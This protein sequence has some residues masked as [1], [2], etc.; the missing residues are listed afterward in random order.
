MSEGLTTLSNAVRPRVVGRYLGQLGIVLALLN[1]VTLAVS[2]YFGELAISLQYLL[3]ITVLL[4]IAVPLSRIEA[5][6]QIQSNEALV[7]VALA[8]LL[9]P[10]TVVLP[11]ISAGIAPL[12]ALFEALSGV[13]TTGLSTLPSV[14]ALPRTLLFARAWMQWYG[15]L[16][17]VVFTLAILLGY[18]GSA[19]RFIEPGGVESLV[20]TT[21]H[22]ARRMLTLYALLTGLGALLLWPLIGDGLAALLYSLTALST[23]GFSPTDQS[24]ASLH[25]PAA[26][27]VITL[28][29]LGGVPLVLHYRLLHGRWREVIGDS[30]LLL[31]LLLLLCCA[32]TLA[33]VL[34]LDGGMGW[35]EA[36]YHGLL[37]GA[38]GQSTAGFSTM[39]IAQI[40]DSGKF[41]LIVSMFIGGGLGSTAGGIKV[42]RLLI[43][44]RLLQLLLRRTSLPPHAVTV[45]TLQGRE[46]GGDELQR[47][48]VVIFLFVATI[49]LSWFTFLLY[50]Y[51]PLDAL[52]EVVS[53]TGT[54]GL[55]VGI[56]SP[57]L[58]PA[59]K[60]LL[61]FD[62][63]AGRLEIVALL[64]L[65]YPP[66]WFGKRAEG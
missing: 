65:L 47:A 35:G 43:L 2:I 20:T 58:E 12:D 21:R 66:N 1:G 17:I 24:L 60:L 11:M 15:G 36:G 55:S 62:M 25:G 39:P 29:F 57:Q 8:F 26:A 5:E 46:L 44:L 34:R 53:A 59:L 63:L 37:L 19:R 64:V 50:G 48:M 51:A 10:L 38:S 4:L 14:E 3:L 6:T 56:T 23:G 54:V 22:Y 33:L 31:L 16:G 52:F 9:S 40:G 61:C 13:T 30:E 32:A 28:A 41:A 45:P 27:M 7:I 42:M 18:E 49:L